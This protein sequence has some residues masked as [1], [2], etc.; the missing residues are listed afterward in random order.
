MR[1]LLNVNII[2]SKL[3]ENIRKLADGLEKMKMSRLA[4]RKMAASA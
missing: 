1:R 3:C 4:W 2:G